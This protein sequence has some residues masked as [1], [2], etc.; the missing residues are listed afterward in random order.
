LEFLTKQK[1]KTKKMQ[2]QQQR[3]TIEE[4]SSKLKPILGSKINELMSGEN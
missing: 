2:T 3:L 1:N 4:I